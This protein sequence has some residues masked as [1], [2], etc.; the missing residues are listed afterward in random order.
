MRRFMKGCGITALVLLIVGLIMAVVAGTIQGRTTIEDV[1][2]SVTGGKVN[3]NLGEWGEWGVTVGDNVFNT[4]EDWNSDMKFKIGDN[5]SFD[6]SYEIFKGDM[7]K[8]LLGSNV[9]KLD[10]EAGGCIFTVEQSDDDNFY[11]EG[12]NIG[13]AQG[14]IKN[15]TVYIKAYKSG[16]ISL[17]DIK[18]CKVTL[19]IPAKS[20][21]EE[22]EIQVG[23]G[24]LQLADIKAGD[25][26]AE[27][28]A[29]EILMSD[30]T[31]DNLDV[32]VGMGQI[33]MDNVQVQALDVEVGMGSFDMRGDI[34]KKA[35]LECAM[36][37][38]EMTV[39][40]KEEDFNYHIEGAMGSVAIG[41]NGFAGVA[42]ERS[43]QN[44]AD[45]NMEV[46]CA[47]GNISIWFT[48]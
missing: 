42:Q 24:Q 48:E 32:T 23:A 3:I 43:I 35:D 22:V 39:N 21:F 44:N 47:M 17:N 36:G 38:I 6:K 40:G 15:N 30:M 28:G 18:A 8:T 5:I 9:Q 12:K 1:V 33:S 11:M 46:E 10:I 14:F 27:V 34:L 7:D 26:K 31:A 41:D 45:K 20:S 4:L 29:G 37:N 2:E 13:K 16:K 19:Y 25:L